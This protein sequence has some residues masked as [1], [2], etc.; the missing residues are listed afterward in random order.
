M[1]EL[2]LETTSSAIGRRRAE[3]ARPRPRPPSG[4]PEW[5]ID[6]PEIP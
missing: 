5:L 6:A 2:P 4:V 1:R 3:C